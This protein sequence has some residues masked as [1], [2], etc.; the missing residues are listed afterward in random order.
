MTMDITDPADAFPLVSIVVTTRNRCDEALRAVASCYAQNY[1][2]IE[3][4]V[5]DD[6]SEDDT[7]AAVTRAFP[8][9]R[10]F[11]NQERAGYVYNRNRGF[12]EANGNYV[13]SIDDDAY[14]S[15]SGIV[16]AIVAIFETD[17]T[18]GAV[19][20]PYIEPLNRRSLSSLRKPFRAKP[21][22]ELRNF[23]GCAHA[24]R[25]DVALQLGGYRDFFVHQG[26]ER[27]FCLRLRAAGWRLVYGS[28]GYIV[29]M[30]SP[31]RDSER[32]AYYGARN[33]I[34]FETLNVPF[35]EVLFRIVWVS[36]GMIRYRF[37]WSKLPT[38]V[39]GILAGLAD[40]IRR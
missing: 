7:V 37:A 2:A 38:V 1:G 29:H 17:P 15:H 30:V 26:E 22:E 39:S 5:F 4:L 32:I 6:A 36:Q 21:G 13:F 33:Q 24:V 27:D 12:A 23:I 28:S 34:L 14:F 20:I 16:S 8:K 18:A 9:V 35:P 3:I 10:M 40:T 19:A 11:A 25:R 31:K